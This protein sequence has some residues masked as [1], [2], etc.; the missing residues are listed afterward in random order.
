MTNPQKHLETFCVVMLLSGVTNVIMF[1]VFSI[2]LK[3]ATFHWFMRLKLNTIGQSQDLIDQS[4]TYFVTSSVHKEC[5]NILT[6]R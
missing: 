1:Q 4:L 2:T 6:R 3:K 5:R